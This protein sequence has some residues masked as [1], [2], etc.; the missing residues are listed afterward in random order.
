ML[1]MLK[2]EQRT[3]DCGN[4]AFN[5]S[6]NYRENAVLMENPKWK[7]L[8]F[9]S[10]FSRCMNFCFFR[11]FFLNFSIFF[12]RFNEARTVSISR[13]TICLPDVES[14][15]DCSLMA[16]ALDVLSGFRLPESVPVIATDQHD[17]IE[18]SWKALKFT[19][20]WIHQKSFPGF[21][22][23]ACCLPFTRITFLI[24]ILRW[25]HHRDRSKI[26]V[27]MWIT[28]MDGECGNLDFN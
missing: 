11:L 5:R 1:R 19:K 16:H 15:D 22:R 25:F 26:A 12:L 17:T 4:C 9:V 23:P 14:G 18:V 2:Q 27:K 6:R 24:R 3:K 13:H 10:E 20:I 21:H 7:T 8:S 28:D